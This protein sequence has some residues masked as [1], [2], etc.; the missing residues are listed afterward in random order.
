MSAIL[1]FLLLFSA[2]AA[3]SAPQ[4]GQPAPDF[5]LPGHDGKSHQLNQ[6]KGKFVV[7]E[8][9]NN[10]CPYV[11]KH[12]DEDNRNMQSLQKN[13]IKKAKDE[14]KELVWF[15]IISSAPGRQGYATAPEAKAIRDQDRQAHM[16]AI[17][18]D[19]DGKVGQ[20]Y[21][22]ETTPHMYVVDDHGILRYQG[23]I[24][25]NPSSRV[26]TIA[27]ARNYVTEALDALMAGGSVA[28]AATQPYG[29]SV[30]Y[31]GGW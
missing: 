22:A 20:L 7:L 30:K 21:D 6:H 17:L 3:W 16:T 9:F 25:D 5:V 29:C 18:L 12:Y 10:E 14:G 8:W 1:I 2:S 15:S 19:P 4:V 24:D 23:A 31:S 11:G 27:G 13:W 28:Y 26:S